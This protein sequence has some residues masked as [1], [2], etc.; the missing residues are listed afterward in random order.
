MSNLSAFEQL[1][2]VPMLRLHDKIYQAADGRR[3]QPDREIN[4]G[5]RRIAVTARRAT[6]DDADHPRLWEM[7][8]K[9]NGN[10][11][12]GYQSL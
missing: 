3:T 4:V 1:V 9:N 8:N 7:V 11:Y 2:G 12:S 5:P 10:R 6:P